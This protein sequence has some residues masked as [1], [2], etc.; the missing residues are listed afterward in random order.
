M[1]RTILSALFVTAVAGAPLIA[2]ANDDINN[3]EKQGTK[4]QQQGQQ[5][6]QKGDD[7]EQQGRSL[8][9]QGAKMKSTSDTKADELST[10]AESGAANAGSDIKRDSDAVKQKAVKHTKKTTTEITE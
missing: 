6:E 2:S 7:L 8:Q 4:L 3:L 10:G 1:K 9:K 5:L